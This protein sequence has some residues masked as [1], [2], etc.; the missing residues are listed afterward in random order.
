ML[1]FDAWPKGLSCS[2]PPS[3]EHRVSFLLCLLLRGGKKKVLGGRQ[4]WA[5]L[6]TPWQHPFCS[7]PGTAH[8]NPPLHGV[9]LQEPQGPATGAACMVSILLGSP[10]LLPAF[11][12]SCLSSSTS[13]VYLVC[14][15]CPP[16]QCF[17][18]T[19]HPLLPV[20]SS[21]STFMQSRL[22]ASVEASPDLCA[23]W[24]PASPRS[25]G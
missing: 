17:L 15:H 8:M 2:K 4:G 21:V 5:G 7:A 10:L 13:R 11:V 9:W 3:Q 6:P 23:G 18:H 12:P 24:W 1:V 14:H 16:P 19:S 22:P 20:P 25:P